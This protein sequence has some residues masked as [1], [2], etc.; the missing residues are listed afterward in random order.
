MKGTILKLYF[1]ESFSITRAMLVTTSC[2]QHAIDKHIDKVVG[3]RPMKSYG[4]V[5]SPYRKGL[6]EVE[7][8]I[9]AVIFFSYHI[10]M[11]K[12][13]EGSAEFSGSKSLHHILH[14]TSR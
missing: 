1:L 9:L 10:I 8:E 4:H 5:K 11:K 6:M 14:Q 12:K 13:I 7:M 2:N 3:R